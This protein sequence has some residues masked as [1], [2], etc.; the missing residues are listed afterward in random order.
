M[1][2]GTHLFV[3]KDDNVPTGI[4]MYIGTHYS[5]PG[6]DPKPIYRIEQLFGNKQYFVTPDR[7][8]PPTQTEEILYGNNK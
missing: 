2:V 1:L 6:I 7:T 8:R 5:K 3:E 4:Y